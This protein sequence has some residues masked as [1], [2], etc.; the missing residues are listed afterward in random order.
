MPVPKPHTEV[1]DLNQRIE[2][3]LVDSW[4]AMNMSSMPTAQLPGS[5]AGKG[6]A[7]PNLPAFQPCPK[8]QLSKIHWFGVLV[9][10]LFLGDYT[11]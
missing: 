5:G 6:L 4:Q 8:S 1:A 7:N 9:G 2:E 11:F 3:I 10:I